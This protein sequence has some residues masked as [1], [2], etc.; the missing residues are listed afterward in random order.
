MSK[1]A[2]LSFALIASALELAPVPCSG[3]LCLD[4]LLTKAVPHGH[5]E[6]AYS[7]VPDGGG[8]IGREIA[9][10]FGIPIDADGNF[11][12][13]ENA[14]YSWPTP[15]AAPGS[16]APEGFVSLA[17]HEAAL[18]R[19]AQELAELRAEL[20]KPAKKALGDMQKRAEKAEADLA[21][22]A[23]KVSALKEAISAKSEAGV[24]A[25]LLALGI[26]PPAEAEE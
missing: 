21:D 18:S 19:S 22:T 23:A 11:A 1:I 13:E 24:N 20:E 15:E 14:V 5:E 4:R 10:G 2:M 8:M 25:A 26:D 17:D 12:P 9:E 16:E 6:A 7:L 3:G